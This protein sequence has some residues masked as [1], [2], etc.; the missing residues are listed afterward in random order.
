[1]EEF[2][3][4]TKLCNDSSSL[5]ESVV[6]GALLSFFSALAGEGLDLVL[7]GVLLFEERRC[8]LFLDG[9]GD[10]LLEDDEKLDKL[11]RLL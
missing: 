3:F 8:E 5:L 7:L 1:M 9:L 11:E 10:E 4:L 2:F 6:G